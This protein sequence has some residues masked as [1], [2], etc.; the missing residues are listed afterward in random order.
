MD[1][2]RIS[3]MFSQEADSFSS[4]T[5]TSTTSTLSTIDVIAGNAGIP[6][7]QTISAANRRKR[8]K[9]FED[10]REFLFGE[11]DF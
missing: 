3:A 11:S 2:A 8:E 5:A 4:A 10:A 9:E 7:E 6:D 1:T